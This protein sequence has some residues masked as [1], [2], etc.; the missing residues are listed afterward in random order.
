MDQTVT[1][2]PS[3]LSI[4]ADGVPK[5]PLTTSW[6]LPTELTVTYDEPSL[7]PTAIRLILPA[8]VADFR[9]IAGH[10]VFPFD[11]EAIPF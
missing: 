4:I 7:D 3:D 8:A 6:A 9:E 10:L 5:V 2:L 1:P 11:I